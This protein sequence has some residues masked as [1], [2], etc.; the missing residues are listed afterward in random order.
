MGSAPA[1]PTATSGAQN[2]YMSKNFTQMIALEASDPDL[3]RRL[4][5]E[6]GM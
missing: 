1:N 5:A 2:P 3:A 4:K 6:A